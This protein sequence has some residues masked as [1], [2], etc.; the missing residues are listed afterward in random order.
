MHKEEKRIKYLEEA[1]SKNFPEIKDWD[2]LDS[3]NQHIGEVDNVLVDVQ[4][5][6]IRYL[7]V[8]LDSKI[9]NSENEKLNNP[10]RSKIEGDVH[11][12]I[13]VG[14]VRLDEEKYNIISDELTKN[15]IS[16]GPLH[17]KGDEIPPEY[18]RNVVGLLKES[19]TGKPQNTY[20][21]RAGAVNQEFY[22]GSYFDLERF[23]NRR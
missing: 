12:L 1:E 23:Y 13:P 8:R 19:D 3:F 20:S 5:E 22:R 11:M 6:V 16:R 17:K 21:E 7:D 15:I 9:A 4:D 2:V 10:N 14:M 18:E